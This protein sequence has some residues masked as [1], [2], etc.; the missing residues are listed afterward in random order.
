M[1]GHRCPCPRLRGRR[2]TRFPAGTGS[3][4]ALLRTTRARTRT[5]LAVSAVVIVVLIV[6]AALLA[7]PDYGRLHEDERAAKWRSRGGPARDHWL[8]LSNA[9]TRP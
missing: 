1:L 2:R 5:L 4:N 7:S 6:V 9:S 8:K 3:M